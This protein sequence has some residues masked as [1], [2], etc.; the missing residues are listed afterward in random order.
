VMEKVQPDE[1]GVQISI[2]HRM[3]MTD[4]DNEN[5]GYCGGS[6][7]VKSSYQRESSDKGGVRHEGTCSCAFTVFPLPDAR[8]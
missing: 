7:V 3:S 5:R 8:P 1:P 2:Y 6:L 4:C